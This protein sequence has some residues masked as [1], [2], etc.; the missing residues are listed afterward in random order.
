MIRRLVPRTSEAANGYLLIAT[1]L[2]AIWYME[3]LRHTAP[4]IFDVLAGGSII[5]HGFDRLDECVFDTG[6]EGDR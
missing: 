1:G 3:M 4:F 2:V 5:L 6:A